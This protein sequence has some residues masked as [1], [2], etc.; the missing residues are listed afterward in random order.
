MFVQIVRLQ[1]ADSVVPMLWIPAKTAHPVRIETPDSKTLPTSTILTSL[2]KGK[3]VSEA[4]VGEEARHNFLRDEYAY[5]I[6]RLYP[7][8]VP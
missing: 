6:P 7:T 8:L 5:S 1:K 2:E 3:S 4:E